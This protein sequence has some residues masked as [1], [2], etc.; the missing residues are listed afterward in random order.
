MAAHLVDTRGDYV[1][2]KGRHTGKRLRDLSTS[3]LENLR[4]SKAKGTH[5]EFCKEYARA[6]LALSA[7]ARLDFSGA[8]NSSLVPA[9]KVQGDD[10]DPDLGKIVPWKPSPS[11]RNSRDSTPVPIRKGRSA[12]SVDKASIWDIVAVFLPRADIFKVLVSAAVLSGVFLLLY[13]PLAAIPAYGIGFALRSLVQRI[14]SC[15]R[16]FFTALD[17]ELGS[18]GRPTWWT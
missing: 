13:P 18:I 17:S 2:A 11:S 10:I 3:E 1:V 14:Q 8:P 5:A 12:M 15:A 7:L 6:F 9:E 4:D 16:E